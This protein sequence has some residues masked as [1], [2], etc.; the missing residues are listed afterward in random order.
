MRAFN[1]GTATSV[2]GIEK[3]S[4]LMTDFSP[5]LV[6]LGSDKIQSSLAFQVLFFDHNNFV[7]QDPM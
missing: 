6:R 1:Y 7:A 4:N 3:A 2:F 5:Q